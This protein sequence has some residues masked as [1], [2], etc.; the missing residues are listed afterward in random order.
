MVKVLTFNELRKIKDSLPDG[1]IHQ[2]AAEL[3]IPIETVWNYFGGEHFVKGRPNG[4]HTEQG[5][6]GGIIEL[7]DTKI[8]D[9]AMELINPVN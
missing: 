8:L 7:D 5:P 9:R 6:E 2:I 1:S 3:N 4:V